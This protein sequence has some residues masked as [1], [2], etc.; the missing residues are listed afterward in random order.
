MNPIGIV[1]F[2]LRHEHRAL[3]TRSR[4][5]LITTPPGTAGAALLDNHLGAIPAGATDMVSLATTMRCSFDLPFMIPL[6]PGTYAVAVRSKR[7]KIRHD[8]ARQEHLDPRLGVAGGRFRLE[9][10]QQGLVRYSKV[11]FDLEERGC[12][13]T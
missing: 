9:R 10:D 11:G 1:R 8:F 6:E 3:H 12:P 5:G 2:G 7:V 13:V 4:P